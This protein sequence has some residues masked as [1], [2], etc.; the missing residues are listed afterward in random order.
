MHAYYA[1]VSDTNDED[2]VLRCLYAL[3]DLGDIDY[4]NEDTLTY[5]NGKEKDKLNDVYRFIFMDTGI[6]VQINNKEKLEP[7]LKTIKD[8]DYVWK[9]DIH[10]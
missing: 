6:N 4:F 1:F 9:V 10:I 5:F 2:K 3:I 8:D 7:V